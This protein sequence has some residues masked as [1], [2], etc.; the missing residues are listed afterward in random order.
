[1]FACMD[2]FFPFG[3]RHEVMI[4]HDISHLLCCIHVASLH[5]GNIKCLIV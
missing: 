5:M 2:Y 4:Y 3:L 1:M